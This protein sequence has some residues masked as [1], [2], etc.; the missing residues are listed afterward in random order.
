MSLLYNE[1]H[2]H[3]KN[4]A[5]FGV[6]SIVLAS[7]IWFGNTKEDYITIVTYFINVN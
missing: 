1:K 2:A 4:V 3:L 7:G 6:S 5:L